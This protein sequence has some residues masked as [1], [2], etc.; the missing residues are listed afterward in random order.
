MID[1]RGSGPWSSRITKLMIIPN[2]KTL[3]HV[4]INVHG[5]DMRINDPPAGVDDTSDLPVTARVFVINHRPSKSP[6]GQV[7]D[8]HTHGANSTVEIFDI[9]IGQDYM[10]HVR[11]VAHP[12]IRT[13]NSIAAAGP[14]SFVFTNDHHV[15]TGHTRV[16]DMLQKRSDVGY[17]S[18]KGCKVALAPLTFPNGIIQG[19]SP[20]EFWI[21]SSIDG[22]ARQTEL[23][24][25]G[26]LVLGDEVK[27]GYGVDNLTRDSEGNIWA[28]AFP[29]AL[30]IVSQINHPESRRASTAALR[31]SKNTGQGAFYGDKVSPSAQYWSRRWER[32]AIRW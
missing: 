7:L 32:E 13:P 30:E 16:L 24:A 17:C 1:T 6:D 10:T 19:S 15:K 3:E 18:A 31:L 12:V 4:Q 14:D 9:D 26:S 28:A 2:P 25:D 27:V 23:Q 20:R 8:G 11:T 21:G 5:F 29:K 22:I